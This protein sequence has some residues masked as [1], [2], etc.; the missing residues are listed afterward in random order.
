M[1]PEDIFLILQKLVDVPEISREGPDDATLTRILEV[2]KWSPTA[3]NL[4]P[5]EI[6]LVRDP[7][8]KE[9]IV[10]VTLDALMRDEPASRA[11]WLKDVPSIIIFCADV[12]G[13]RA[14]F[15]RDRALPIAVGDLGGFLLTF[16]VV[17]L[18]EGWVTGIVR[19]FDPQGVRDIFDIP[20]FIEPLALMAIGRD[21]ASLET[22]VDRPTMEV[23]DFFHHERW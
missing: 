17:A 16:R 8:N 19:E 13:V 9:K 2:A 6:I 22:V 23:K 4:Q 14:R 11:F 7:G 1:K 18:S 12:K 20:K 15:G 10:E 21:E 5:W 3:A